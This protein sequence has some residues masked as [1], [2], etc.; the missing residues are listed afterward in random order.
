MSRGAAFIPFGADCLQ[1]PHRHRVLVLLASS[2]GARV[3]RRADGTQVD[4]DWNRVSRALYLK[5][6]DRLDWRLLR[7]NDARRLFGSPRR[8]CHSGGRARPVAAGA[9]EACPGELRPASQHPGALAV[10]IVGI[11]EPAMLAKI[12][13]YILESFAAAALI[14]PHWPVLHE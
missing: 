11:G 12:V 5:L 14:E 9:P 1:H 6:P 10:T 3:A 2:P 4:F 7:T 8:H 13:A